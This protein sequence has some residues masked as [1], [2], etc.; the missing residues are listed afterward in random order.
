[1]T[2]GF[3]RTAIASVLACTLVWAAQ[4]LADDGAAGRGLAFALLAGGAFGLLLQR[5]RFCFFCV[6]RDF[7][8]RRDARGLLGIVAA[9]A[10][11]TVGY[12]AVFG[13]FLPIPAEGRLPPGAH[14]GPVSIVLVLGAFAFGV[15]MS[16]SGSCIGAHLYRLGEGSTG[17]PIALLGAGLG[18][19]LGFLSWNTLYLDLVVDAP[20]VWLPAHLGYGGALLLQL[21]VLGG[22]AALLWRAHRQPESVVGL[23]SG[24][25]PGA[26][27]PPQPSE[28]R[29]RLIDALFGTRW[30]TW[31]G[32][33]LIGALATVTYFRMGALGVTAELGSLARTGANALDLLPGRLEG[34][35]TFAG[36]ATVVKNALLSNNGMFVS[37]LVTASLASAVLAS[38][39]RPRRI[40]LGDVLR[41]FVGGVLMGWGAMVALG[42]TVGV[43]LSGIMAGA[44]SGWVFAIACLGGI[45]LSLRVEQLVRRQAG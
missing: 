38:D 29:L 40:P 13:A 12:F 27:Q 2:I 9:L 44:L 4:R 28:H 24:D 14:I 22:V 23:A 39:F 3:V 17:A 19:V 26:A 21:T 31:M 35:D 45:W 16:L 41:K 18:F 43:L 10:V 42:C 32:G 37:G 15:G 6:A 11:G 34:L 20:V 30:P 7:I 8:E 36:C 5:S 1:M 33:V 25:V